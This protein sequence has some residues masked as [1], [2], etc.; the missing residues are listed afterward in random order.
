MPVCSAFLLPTWHWTA[1]QELI[2]RTQ[3]LSAC[4][5]FKIKPFWQSSR[6]SF[7]SWS[8]HSPHKSRIMP[9]IWIRGAYS[10]SIVT[11]LAEITSL[12]S[13]LILLLA[14]LR[15]VVLTHGWFLQ[16]DVFV[17]QGRMDE[18]RHLLSKEVSAN[19]T[20][21]NMYKI[22]DDLMK[23]MPVPSVCTKWISFLQFHWEKRT[24]S[25][26]VPATS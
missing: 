6:P 14:A 23:K 8:F 2:P 26:V 11:P 18:A 15:S 24:V 25:D 3:L 4:I 12:S 16:V 10:L 5:G 22:L 20:S 13:P 17:L 1:S 19:P 21:M 7:A 9:C